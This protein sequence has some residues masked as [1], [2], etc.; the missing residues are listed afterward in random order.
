MPPDIVAP[1]EASNTRHAGKSKRFFFEKKKQKTSAPAGLGIAAATARRTKVFFASF[2]FTKKRSP[3]F[4]DSP[5]LVS[6][7][8]WP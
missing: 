8:S 5:Y 3:S 6:P 1:S 2:L 4:L 7:P